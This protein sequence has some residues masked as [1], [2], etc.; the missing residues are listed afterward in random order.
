MLRSSCADTDLCN[1]TSKITRYH[2]TAVPDGALARLGGVAARAGAALVPAGAFGPFISPFRPLITP[3]RP[4]IYTALTINYTRPSNRQC[5]VATVESARLRVVWTAGQ[6]I[7]NQSG[8]LN[9]ASITARIAP[10]VVFTRHGAF[11]EPR[12]SAKKRRPRP[13]LGDGSTPPRR[14]A[15]AFRH[16]VSPRSF[17]TAF[18]HGVSPRRFATAFRHGVSPRRFA[19]AFGRL[20]AHEGTVLPPSA[21]HTHTRVYLLHNFTHTWVPCARPHTH[22][23]TLCTTAHTRGYLLHD[24]TSC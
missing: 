12:H 14:F 19:T 5:A 7:K 16:G 1:N 13:R 23:G 17:A 3:F 22:V 2:A 18:R 20:V 9:N 24:C 15:T 8:R 4:L 11:A 10:A 6:H 21:V